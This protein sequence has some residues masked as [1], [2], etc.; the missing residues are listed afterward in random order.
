[1][2]ILINGRNPESQIGNDK[3]THTQYRSDL[4]FDQNRNRFP[5]KESFSNKIIISQYLPS[6]DQS[7]R[8]NSITGK[9]LCKYSFLPKMKMWIKLIFAIFSCSWVVFAADII[10]VCPESEID[11]PKNKITL[12]PVPAAYHALVQVISSSLQTTL[13]LEYAAL[14][15]SYF[16]Q[17]EQGNAKAIAIYDK[18][19][20]QLI[21]V[22]ERSHKLGE[23]ACL[24]ETLN[25]QNGWDVGKIEHKNITMTGADWYLRYTHMEGGRELKADDLGRS[26]ENG[27]EVQTYG[28]CLT[29]AEINAFVYMKINMAVTN[30]WT[31]LHGGNDSVPTSVWTNTSVNG[32]LST[33]FVTFFDYEK[34]VVPDGIFNVPDDCFCFG[35]KTVGVRTIPELPMKFSY[36]SEIITK[37]SDYKDLIVYQNHIF[38]SEMNFTRFDYRLIDQ[39]EKYDIGHAH[40]LEGVLTQIHDFYSGLSYTFDPITGKCDAVPIPLTSDDVKVINGKKV[41]IT[42]PMEYLGLTNLNYTFYK[43][44]RRRGIDALQ[45]RAYDNKA[46][47]IHEYWFASAKEVIQESHM[48]NHMQPMAH[49]Q[50]N[51]WV[52]EFNYF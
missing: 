23:E 50:Y 46:F 47:L 49:I 2:F 35:L 41:I 31:N 8:S 51:I 34:D 36:Q 25:D 42:T 33:D 10:E 28:L 21:K 6:V 4:T 3:A 29:W 9:L 52:S 14:G 32:E 27:V 30:K 26:L 16:R 39:A 11:N 13:N 19:R 22:A 37:A 7:L 38:D 17:V 45:F 44:E 24:V 1:M 40:P 5:A 18:K 43:E 20:G 15:G 12:P 48:Y